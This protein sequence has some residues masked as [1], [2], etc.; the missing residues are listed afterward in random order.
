MAS[1]Y[2]IELYVHC[3]MGRV[4]TLMGSKGEMRNRAK[5]GACALGLHFIQFLS[6]LIAHLISSET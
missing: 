5:Q 2:V 4:Y 3:A 6:A 1:C